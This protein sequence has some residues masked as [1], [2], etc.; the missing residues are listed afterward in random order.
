M[1]AACFGE[2]FGLFYRLTRFGQFAFFGQRNLVKLL[3]QV[4][5]V[6]WRMKAFV[7]AA[8]VEGGKTFSGFGDDV[9]C[10]TI[11]GLFYHDVMVQNELMLVFQN[12]DSDTQLNWHT[13]FAFADPF[14]MRLKNGKYFFCVR[15]GFALDDSA[16][17]LADLTLCMPDVAFDFNA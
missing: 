5:L 9:C 15:N 2:L 13:G 8:G 17:D 16:F 10:N 7:E 1:R 14:G 11:I 3:G 4:S 6:G 12:A